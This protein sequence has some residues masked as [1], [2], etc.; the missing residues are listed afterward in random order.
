MTDIK[1]QILI[2]KIKNKE[3]INENT[4]KLIEL[5]STYYKEIKFYLDKINETNGEIFPWKKI[6]YLNNLISKINNFYKTKFESFN[7]DKIAKKRISLI[8][9]KLKIWNFEYYGLEKPT[10]NDSIYDLT[11]R[12]LNELEKLF[13]KYYSKSSPTHTV[14]GVIDNKFLKIKHNIPMLSLSNIFSYEEL[15]KFDKTNKKLLKNDNIPMTYIIEPKLDGLSISLIYKN[16]ILTNGITR[17][18]GKSGEDVTQN[19]MVIDSIPKKIDCTLQHLEIRGEILIDFKQFEKINSEIEEEKNKFANPRNAASGTLRRL[20]PELVKKRNLK[21]IAYYIPDNESLKQLN[22]NTQYDVIRK[23]NQF[24]FTTA[25]EIKKCHD[26][27]EVYEHIKY[28]EDNHDKLSY[29]IDGAVIKI[30]ELNLY[31]KLGTT[32]KFPHWATAYKFIPLEAETKILAINAN[33]GRTGKITYV[34]KLEPV[35]LSGSTISS[36]TL[37]NAEYIVNKD[38]RVGD[39]I[40]IF[41][42]AEII[43]YVKEAIKEKRNKDVKQ[44]TPIEYCPICNSKLEKN[45]GEVDQYCPNTSCPA[46]I[47][48]SIIHFCSKDA[49]NIEGL[50]TKTIKKYFNLGYIK[51]IE[52]IYSLNEKREE[53]INNVLNKKFK[54]FN[55]II[56]SIEKSKNNSLER[57]IFGLGINNIGLISAISLAKHFKTIDEIIQANKECLIRLKDIAEVVSNSIYDWFHNERNISLIEHLKSIGVN[58]KYLNQNVINEENKKS[59]YY[60]K[61]FCITGSFTISRNE[62]KEKLIKKYD[63]NVTNSL[64]R[65]TNYLIVGENPGSKID[66]A[67]ELNI[68]IINE[69]I[70]N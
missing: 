52:D 9:N 25:K 47:L 70:W 43:P 59:E 32:S 62:I 35:Y 67:K 60:Q 10:V 34:A 65:S 21:M 49:M 66:K 20:D 46:R 23:L 39:Y 27:N 57:L 50:S 56:E 58:T 30:N 3:N 16:G 53:I 29:P 55:K 31:D 36:A 40:K 24:G 42:A 33:V 11:L 61:N 7:I 48:Q 45:E 44:F 4:N 63:A 68:K 28:L 14:G 5:T 6:I 1:L 17:G 2:N 69:E 64:N 19:I 15:N 13:P 38:I 26:I 37:N 22:L 54:V 12:E 8:R 51:T 18:D 41:K